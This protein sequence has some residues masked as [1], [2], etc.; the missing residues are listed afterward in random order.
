MSNVEVVREDVA[1]DRR[2]GA[3]DYPVVTDRNLKGYQPQRDSAGRRL[4]DRFSVTDIGWVSS[5][6][7][8]GIR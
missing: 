2:R 4:F 5:L 3:Q 8:E 7:A 1:D 6:V